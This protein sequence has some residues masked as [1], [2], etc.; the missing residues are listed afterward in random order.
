MSLFSF[1]GKRPE[2]LGVKEG[3]LLA[4]P[5]SPNC[6][7]SQADPSDQ[8]HFIT[9]IAHSGSPS[10]AIAKLKAIIEGMERS[11]IIEA[12]DTYLWAMFTSKLMGFGDDL[13]FY[14]D[15]NSG[16]I[17]VRC[18]ARLGRSD[19]G[20]NRKRVEAIREQFQATP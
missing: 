1:T 9:P 12:N 15:P 6:V 8:E 18:A 7:N 16:V 17:Q 20:A 14:A 4:C 5:S 19:L 13:E 10:E 3:K 2:N 11:T